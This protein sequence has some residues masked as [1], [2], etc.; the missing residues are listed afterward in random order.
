M[1]R[2]QTVILEHFGTFL[3]CFM[4]DCFNHVIMSLLAQITYRECLQLDSTDWIM[5][6][7]SR[8]LNEDDIKQLRMYPILASFQG[9][10]L[11]TY[12]KSKYLS[13]LYARF[14][15]FLVTFFL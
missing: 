2:G 14:H 5:K 1:S 15:H 12:S 4:I 11:L 8:I 7:Y 10:S 6:L 9:S 13:P 3:K